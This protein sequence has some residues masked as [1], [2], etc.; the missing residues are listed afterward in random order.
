MI[1]GGVVA[2]AAG[3]LASATIAACGADATSNNASTNVG[4]CGTAV[5]TASGRT[6]DYIV[7]LVASGAGA[8]PSSAAPSSLSASS[9][10]ASPIPD[11]VV[12]GTLAHVSGAGAT[13]IALSI[14]QRSTGAVA[15]GLHPDVTLRN[16]TAGTT[17]V[18]MPVA[19]F[20][21]KGQGVNDL[22]YGNNVNLEPGD[23][24]TVTVAIDA[25]NTVELTYQAPSNAPTP[26]PGPPQCIL[27]HQMC[28]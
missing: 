5:G 14:C 20:E 15:T 24:Y 22:H 28:E 13:H 18:A 21:G 19:V 23:I 16:A 26:T 12:S 17:P 2:A 7:V 10:S 25:A 27:N 9:P 6:P 1:R 8:A 11:V 4:V 3:L